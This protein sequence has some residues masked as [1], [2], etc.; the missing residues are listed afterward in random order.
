MSKLETNTIDT[1]SGTSNL[2]IGSSNASTITLKSGA[3]LTN[4]PTNTPAFKSYMSADQNLS[5]NTWTKVNFDTEAFDTNSMYDTGTYRFTPTVAGKYFVYSAIILESLTAKRIEYAN[6]SIY[7]NGSPELKT[8]A[9]YSA[10]NTSWQAG[11]VI[12]TV[13]EFNGSSDYVES[14][15]RIKTFSGSNKIDAG[16]SYDNVFGAYKIIE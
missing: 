10:D 13:V 15:A 14:Y 16:N 3:T 1:I 6:A 7:K 8:T 4:F 5:D 9:V 2:T 12:S 11:G